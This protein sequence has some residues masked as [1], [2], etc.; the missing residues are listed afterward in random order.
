MMD[1]PTPK[2][3]I[4]Q[5]KEF[6]ILAEQIQSEV[7]SLGE[8]ERKQKILELGERYR[9]WYRKA[10]SIFSIYGRDELEIPFTQEFEGTWI[11]PKIKRFLEAGWKLY[12]YYDP[13]KE[14]PIIPKW[15]VTYER[16]FKSPLEKQRDLL[17]ILDAK[18]PKSD[19]SSVLKTDTSGW[20]TPFRTI[21]EGIK[22]SSIEPKLKEVAIYDLEQAQKAYSAQAYKA[23]IVMLG[24]VLEGIMLGTLRRVDVIYYIQASPNPP[25][26]LK[27]IGIQDP[28]L[29][30][31]IA[32]KLSFEVFK[33]VLHDLAPEIEKDK[34]Q[35]I[36]TF[37]NT[38]HPWNTVTDPEIYADPDE[39][40]AIYHLTSLAI[41]ARY[42]LQ[43]SPQNEI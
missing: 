41:L 14:N 1:N 23:C 8:D 43:W 35:N 31:K 4:V 19:E 40:R 6:I 28:Q 2:I 20:D 36:Q 32:Q 17:S 12:A 37:R 10:L 42:I 30:D 22:A 15:T 25:T 24:A 18:C 21:L 13:A 3:L 26:E 5:A 38:I 39:I 27:Q 11:S 16:S 7:Q 9:E 29:A 34:I 33:N